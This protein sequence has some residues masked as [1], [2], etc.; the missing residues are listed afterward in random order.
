MLFRNENNLITIFNSHY[1]IL[2]FHN[3]LYILFSI[4]P[5]F[6]FEIQS[7]FVMQSHEEVAI[8]ILV[9]TRS[10]ESLRLDL[11][12]A[13]GRLMEVTLLVVRVCP[14]VP[15]KTKCR[16]QDRNKNKAEE[17]LENINGLFIAY[18]NAE[19]LKHILV[20]VI[21]PLQQIAHKNVKEKMHLKRMV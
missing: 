14:F 19:I 7:A 5:V 18:I 3:I 15:S 2:D 11:I 6:P 16:P 12:R 17:N 8:V 9:E 4:I 13:G 21:M 1:K 10:W 20:Y